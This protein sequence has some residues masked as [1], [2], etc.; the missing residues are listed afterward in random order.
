MVQTLTDVGPTHVRA[1]NPSHS[2]ES[3]SLQD[4]NNQQQPNQQ[5]LYRMKYPDRRDPKPPP[6]C[7]CA[8]APRECFSRS[9]R[10]L[11]VIEITLTGVLREGKNAPAF[12]KFAFADSCEAGV[13]SSSAIVNNIIRRNA[14]YSRERNDGT[15]LRRF[16]R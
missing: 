2:T 12:H 11:V 16:L 8:P 6:P 15:K 9:P 7:D 10:S 4:S 13:L 14:L 3:P 5:G 1:T